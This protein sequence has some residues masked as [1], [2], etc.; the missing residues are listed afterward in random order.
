MIQRPQTSTLLPSPPLFFFFFNDTATTEIYTLSLHDA[1]PISRLQADYGP[2]EISA[3]SGWGI[4]QWAGAAALVVWLGL[5]VGFR[6][7]L[8]VLSFGLLWMAAAILPVS[9]VLLPTGVALAERTLYLASVGAALAIG[10]VLAVVPTRAARA[11]AIAAVA[12]LLI[13]G[14]VRSATRG[15]VLRAQ[16]TLC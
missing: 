7:R 10:G 15:R 14:V 13:L 5:A 8:P 16:E 4:G 3:A 1:L 2:N 12:A 6:R 11:V 9:N